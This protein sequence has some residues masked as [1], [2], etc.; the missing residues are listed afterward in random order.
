MTDG[1]L[2]ERLA[3]TRERVARAAERAGRDPRSVQILGAAKRVP[4]ERV[5][6]AIRAG[7]SVVGENYVQE[8]AAKRAAIPEPAEWHLIG[9]LQR[10]KAAA[11]VGLFDVIESVGSLAVGQALSRRAVQVGSRL[12]VLVEVNVAAEP[13]KAGVP[14]ADAR[15]LVQALAALPGLQVEGLMGIPPP[16]AGAEQARPHFATLKRAWD[17]LDN[18]NRRCLSMGMSADFEVAIEEGATLVRVGTLL[19][20]PRP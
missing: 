2:A 1:S 12:R 15:D 14:P 13:T 18:E 17:T 10:N 11:A 16:V 19:F 9:P 6:E 8:A 5:R 7:L 20:G 4:A 3:V